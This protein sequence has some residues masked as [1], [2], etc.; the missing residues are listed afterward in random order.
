MSEQGFRGLKW[1]PSYEGEV[2][3]LFGMVLPYMQESFVIEEYTDEFPDCKAKVDGKDV[4]IEF[5]VDSR[6]FFSQKHDK[7]PRLPKC[8]MIICW[9]NP[10]NSVIKLRGKTIKILALSDVVKEKKLNLFL[11]GSR[12]LGPPF[13]PK[14]AFLGKLRENVGDGERYRWVNDLVEFCESCPEFVEVPGRGKRIATLGFQIRKWLSEDIGD[15]TPI[16]FGADGGLVIVYRRMPKTVETE[17]RRRMQTPTG[18]WPTIQIQD[19][20]TFNRV[21]DALRWLCETVSAS[22]QK[23]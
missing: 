5:E 10:Y 16:Q 3:I 9:R 15:P 6:N 1:E 19:E 12:P 11:V 17:L 2:L 23:I 22:N 20:E 4:G 18:L 21:K 8:N 7:D 13:W 14:E